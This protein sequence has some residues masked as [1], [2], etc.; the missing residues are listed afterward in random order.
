MRGNSKTMS[1]LTQYENDDVI[2]EVRKVLTESVSRLIS[3]GVRRWYITIDPGIGFAKTAE[4][5]FELLRKLSELC[6]PGSPLR[7]IPILVG[8]SR[9][10]FLRMTTGKEDPKDR[11]WATA[12]ACSASV[13]GGAAIIRVHDVKEMKDVVSTSDLLYRPM[14]K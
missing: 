2:G 13:V 8:P 6:S 7:G 3:Q 4:Q 9:K 10:G 11:V 12:A 5:N 1:N 14:T